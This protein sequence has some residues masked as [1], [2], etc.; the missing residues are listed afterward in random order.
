M[1]VYCEERPKGKGRRTW[2]GIFGNK[3]KKIDEWEVGTS[4][5]IGTKIKA[6]QILVCFKSHLK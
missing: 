6:L 4:N 1:S 3:I 2:R 5:E